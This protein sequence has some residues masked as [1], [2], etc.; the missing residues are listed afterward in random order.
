[1]NLKKRQRLNIHL[2]D[3]T[4]VVGLE[5]IE[6]WDGADLALL[7]EVLSELIEG[8]GFRSVGV[9]L[10]PVK[11]IPSGFFGMLFEWYETGIEIQLHSPQKNVERMLWFR[12][13][14]TVR[15]DGHFQ[16]SD[17]E[18]RNHTPNQQVEY[19]KR[20]FMDRTRPEEDG[21]DSVRY[22][23]STSGN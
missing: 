18:V 6:I 21:T 7:R 14:F 15:P 19:H 8:D 9:D 4:A 16:L 5:R 20:E 11:Y 22:G 23:V 2:D 12:M 1:M 10:A 3:N 13:F 17:E